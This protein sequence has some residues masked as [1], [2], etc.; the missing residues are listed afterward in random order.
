VHCV[1]VCVCMCEGLTGLAVTYGLNLNIVL[2][3][4]IWNLCN[5]QTKIISVERI[6]QYTCIP[7]EAPLVIE[8]R[9]PPPSWPS[10]GTIELQHLQV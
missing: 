8:S 7:S 9:R 1:C 6:Q 4:V 3:G 10:H 2:V 5:L